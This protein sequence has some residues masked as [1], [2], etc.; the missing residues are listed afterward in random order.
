MFLLWKALDLLPQ[1][2]AATE[3]SAALRDTF[4][5]AVLHMAQHCSG[6]FDLVLIAQSFHMVA[7]A[8]PASIFVD[9]QEGE[10]ARRVNA[11]R[12]L[13]VKTM[14]LK[15]LQGQCS[16]PVIPHAFP[17]INAPVRRCS[18]RATF[19]WSHLLLFSSFRCPH[20]FFGW[21]EA[22]GGLPDCLSF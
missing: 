11:D 8:F 10:G 6:E 4:C 19:L 16:H 1:L 7:Q 5:G 3:S 15:L 18:C 2:D 9:P 14:Y 12:N 13:A 21:L 22:H 17:F 20:R